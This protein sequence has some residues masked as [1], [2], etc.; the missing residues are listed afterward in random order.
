MEGR[1]VKVGPHGYA[2][3]KGAD[4]REYFFHFADAVA[5]W[6]TRLRAKMDPLPRG[7]RVRFSVIGEDDPRGPRAVGVEP[8]DP[9]SAQQGAP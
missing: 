4:D 1:V 3:I 5:P 9:P 2:I 6:R 8:L 7:M